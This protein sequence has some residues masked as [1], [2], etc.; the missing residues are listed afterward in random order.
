MPLP[1]LAAKTRLPH[2]TSNLVPRPRLFAALD[3]CL[4]PDMQ[5]MLA[6]APATTLL[7]QWLGRLPSKHDTNIAYNFL[8]ILDDYNVIPRLT[9]TRRSNC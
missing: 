8:L 5:V 3:A 7:A 2:P 4:N 9:S 6:V 1:F